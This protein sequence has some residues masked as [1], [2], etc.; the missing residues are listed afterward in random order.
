MGDERNEVTI[1]VRCSSDTSQ[2]LTTIA[3]SSVNARSFEDLYFTIKLPH[4]A[5]RHFPL[6]DA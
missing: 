5:R 2:E 6:S 1:S 4:P 3:L